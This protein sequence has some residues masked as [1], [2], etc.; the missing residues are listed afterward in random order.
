MFKPMREIRSAAAID[1]LANRV[2]EIAD[3]TSERVLVA[4]SGPP[5]S[6]KSTIAAAL[7]A[8]LV[9]AGRS[10]ILIPM[11]GFHLDNKVLVRRD[12]LD[13]KGAPET[14]DSAGFLNAIKRLRDCPDVVLPEFDRQRDISVAGAIPVHARDH[15]VVVE[16]NYLCFNED[17]WR[18][19]QPLWHLTAYIDSPRSVLEARLIQRW[20]DLGLS[21]AAAD[22]KVH[23]ND[24]PNADRIA[25]A[26]FDCDLNLRILNDT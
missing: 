3:R 9:D 21:R 12:L 22:Q 26:R 4:V 19:L 13:R 15:V 11:D 25:A 10:A 14:F 23:H 6:G 20:L 16:G 2:N 24:L 8:R 7:A 1:L 5:A 17:P 18:E